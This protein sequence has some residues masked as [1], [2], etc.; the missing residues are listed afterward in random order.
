MA[1]TDPPEQEKAVSPQ[2]AAANEEDE[3]EA[4]ERAGG[5]NYE[6]AGP[7]RSCC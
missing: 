3:A 4:T 2:P 6:S 7:D 1:R 5:D